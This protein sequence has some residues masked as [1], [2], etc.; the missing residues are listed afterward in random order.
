MEQ[1]IKHL[2][3]VLITVI[4]LAI[5][6]L[7]NLFFFVKGKHKVHGIFLDDERNVDDVTWMVYHIDIKWHVVRTYDKFVELLD[8]LGES[9]GL[10]ISLDH[11]IQ[12]FSGHNNSERTGYD[13]VKYIADYFMDHD[14]LSV[15]VVCHSQ[16]PIG[17]KNIESYW[18]NFCNRD[19]A[20]K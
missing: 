8:K 7:V 14:V 18:N 5:A 1:F 16:N 2:D 12:D 9:R 13:V 11:D 10:L 20:R 4:I 3:A 6:Y 19:K 15:N 17:R